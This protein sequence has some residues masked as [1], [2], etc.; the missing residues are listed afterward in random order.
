M[1]FD[2]KYYTNAE[3]ELN[4]IRVKNTRIQSSREKEIF[5]KYPDIAAIN[6]QLLSTAGRLFTLIADKNGDI[7]EKL[8]S[9]E[10][11][12]LNLQRDLKAALKK[13]GYPE[14]YLDPVYNCTICK[15]KGIVN[16]KRCSC[17]MNM[18]K[19]AASDELN[20][21]SPLHLS[22]FD[23]FDITLYDDNEQTKLGATARKIMTKN[24]SFCKEYAENFHLPYK[25][26][27]I[28][29][30]TGL[31]KTHLSLSIASSVLEKGYSVIYCSAPDIFRRIEREHFGI[32]QSDTDTL[33]MLIKT[34][35]LVL[36][37][38]GAEFESKFYSS[39]LYNIINDRLNYSLPII[40]NTNLELSEIE[41]RYGE[42]IS[43][44]IATM[45][46]PIFV[47]SDIRAIKKRRQQ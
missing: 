8:K 20:L 6:R 16:G 5:E 15:D 13:N 32:V 14:D 19:K 36:D 23:E 35:L 22:H 11:E 12:N 2:N 31:G 28:R 1:G 38:L 45:D 24:L 43:S 41:T 46:K 26:V 37:D 18:V 27:L 9:L 29:G 42:R 21:T 33:D 7:S 10:S 3:N 34:D 17:Y 25:S 40:I 47:G 39:V 44:R 4:E 30:K